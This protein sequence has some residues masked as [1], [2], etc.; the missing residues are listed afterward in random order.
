M[1]ESPFGLDEEMSPILAEFFG[2]S[3]SSGPMWSNESLIRD[4]RC[5]KREGTLIE[6]SKEQ[7]K[8]Q[9]ASCTGGSEHYFERRGESQRERERAVRASRY[10]KGNVAKDRQ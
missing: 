3:G 1:I 10:K 8:M 6:L 9:F 2:S 5:S 4:F 7:A